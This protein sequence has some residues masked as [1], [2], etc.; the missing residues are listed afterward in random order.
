MEK[1][2]SWKCVKANR[3]MDKCE[4]NISLGAKRA[5]EL[6]HSRGYEAYLVG[7]C[8]RSMLLGDTISDFD[9]TTNALPEEMLDVFKG[10]KTFDAGFKHGTLSVVIENETVEITTYRV[11][12]EYLDCRHPESVIFTNNLRED[13]ARRDFTMNSLAYSFEE[14]VIDFFGG[15]SDISDKIIR[16]VGNPNKRFEEDALR[17]LRAIRFS[18]TLGFQI[19]KETKEAMLKC[20]HLLKNISAERIA[21][22][23]CKFLLGKNVKK[24]ILDNYEILGELCPEFLT[25][26]GFEQFNKWHIYDV[27]EHTATAVEAIE[28]VHHLRLAMLFHDIGKVYTFFKDENGVGHFYGHNEKSAE[29]V[30]KFLSKYKYDNFTKQEVYEL[31]K[32]HDMYTE[33]NRVLVKKRLNRIGKKRF[34][35]L[36]KIQRADNLAQNPLLTR[37]EHF[38]IL[39]R[40]V[41]E[42]S[43]EECFSLSSLAINGRDLIAIGISQG[44]L[45]GEL[46][47]TLLNEVIEEKI[48]NERDELINRAKELM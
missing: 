38:D 34:L 42:I 27:L 29:I 22:E 19:E 23:L 24:A 39:E 32:I 18:S 9:I 41:D 3:A 31:I 46:L 4:F 43:K 28:P 37:M 20:K 2:S 25:M 33:E 14:G 12:G 11:D 44:K 8:V 6:L 45:I 17:I 35:D 13:L 40:M 47:K 30:K 15:K 21:S 7:G 16:A 36:I 48:K 10:E 1:K 26:K 5:I